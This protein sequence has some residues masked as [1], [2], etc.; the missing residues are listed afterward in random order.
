MANQRLP[1]DPYRSQSD[2]YRSTLAGDDIRDPSRLDN[3]LQ[4]DPEL[5]EGPASG[6][7]I[8]GVRG[9]YRRD[10]GRGLL[11]PEQFVDQPRRHVIDG[12]EHRPAAKHRA[13]PAIPAGA[14]SGHA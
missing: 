7:R 3:E 8:A 1:N 2:P 9:G 10:S 5:A 4:P 14:A 13:K 11:W 6:G 12:A